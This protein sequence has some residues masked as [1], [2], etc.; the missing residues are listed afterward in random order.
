[1]KW[2]QFHFPVKNRHYGRAVVQYCRYKDY[3]TYKCYWWPLRAINFSG[4][5]NCLI[6]IVCRFLENLLFSSVLIWYSHECIPCK[7]EADPWILFC[8]K[9]V[10][11]RP[12]Y[13]SAMPSLI[14]EAVNWLS[15]SIVD[16]SC[17]NG[18]LSIYV[19]DVRSW[20]GFLVM[21]I[22]P[23]SFNI[24]FNWWVCGMGSFRSKGFTGGASWT[25]CLFV[26]RGTPAP[27]LVPYR[28]CLVE[29]SQS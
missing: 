23:V 17:I 21:L 7:I 18:R 6:D 14:P 13:N 16:L 19:V 27:M 12:R 3:L 25:W 26:N 22:P 9:T 29:M 2:L 28:W 10:L 11:E 1:M 24:A 15:Q 8:C 5:C 4:I 20:S